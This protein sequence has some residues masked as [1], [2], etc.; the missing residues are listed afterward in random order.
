MSCRY[1]HRM[2]CNCKKPA[3]PFPPIPVESVG[4][5]WW[6]ASWTQTFQAQDNPYYAS[7]SIEVL[8][9]NATNK[10]ITIT[11]SNTRVINWAVYDS[12]AV[13]FTIEWEW[14]AEVTI[15]SQANP[16]VS[17]TYSVTVTPPEP[18]FS[19]TNSILVEPTRGN[20]ILKFFATDG[21]SVD[22]VQARLGANNKLTYVTYYWKCEWNTYCEDIFNNEDVKTELW[23]K[24]GEYIDTYGIP[25]SWVLEFAPD[26]WTAIE[27]F[28]QWEQ[29]IEDVV[30]AIEEW[31][32]IEP[33]VCRVTITANNP[34]R[35]RTIAPS[36]IDGIY[37]GTLEVERAEANRGR[38]KVYIEGG[39]Y[40]TT[41]VRPNAGYMF[42]R[43]EI[44][45]IEA[46]M[47][48]VITLKGDVSAVGFL[49]PALMNIEISDEWVEEL[50]LWTT[51]YFP[52]TSSPS[53]A[54][55]KELSLAIDNP[56]LA[57]ASIDNWNVVIEPLQEWQISFYLYD[58]YTGV[59]SNTLTFDITE[60][61]WDC[62]VYISDFTADDLNM[63]L[64]ETY[65]STF[66]LSYD[67]ATPD[68]SNLSVTSDDE[69]VATVEP[70]RS[71]EHFDIYS[72]N[73][74]SCV[75]TFTDW[76]NTYSFNVYV[77]SGEPIDG[78]GEV[79][80]ESNESDG[81]WW[82]AFFNFSWDINNLR[83]YAR[84][85]DEEIS[86]EV[87]HV[88]IHDEEGGVWQHYAEVTYYYP[89]SADDLLDEFELVFE[90]TEAPAELT[91]RPVYAYVSFVSDA[92]TAE[93]S[94]PD[95]NVLRT[96]FVDDWTLTA[97]YADDDIAVAA[98]NWDGELYAWWNYNHEYGD[99][100]DDPDA[101]LIY[102]P[103]EAGKEMIHQWQTGI[104]PIFLS[105]DTA[106]PNYYFDLG[107]SEAGRDPD[108]PIVLP[109]GHWHELIRFSYHSEQATN[110]D[111]IHINTDEEHISA[112][113]IDTH[114][115]EWHIEVE[116]LVPGDWRM[117]LECVD[118]SWSYVIYTEQIYFRVDDDGQL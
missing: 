108:N 118:D 79:R 56:E 65:S 89:Q 52:Y 109:A 61:W 27:G 34:E 5:V 81:A 31:E 48:D 116:W 43:R 9:V 111:N 42:D 64:N 22:Y 74:G 95:V 38:L 86:D 114:D 60:G 63:L 66:T 101:R 90:D 99:I 16:E 107:Q 7:F 17:T 19:P 105:S 104:S 20:A 44:N 4:I 8:P 14:D 75:I 77:E 97:T 15:T 12:T 102:K 46:S 100:T 6:D 82:I 35:A 73:T 47:G 69:S 3:K 40:R 39:R 2:W 23:A 115:W 85:D 36:K 70:N 96:L 10:M 30:S 49:A 117:G 29:T 53:E 28:F 76:E 98:P 112:N 13:T 68:Y 59:Q 32:A 18:P 11:S 103:K 1:R 110:F 54:P 21:E 51:Y 94:T 71:E 33:S 41:D 24:I 92:P 62:P 25:A 93:I 80:L 87:V 106:I 55:I 67:C 84:K 83:V 58:G 78:S 113:I 37:N 91:S 57:N 50:T 88:E 45:G 26:M 72:Q